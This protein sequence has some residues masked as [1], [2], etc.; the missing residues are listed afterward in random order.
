M[1]PL[2]EGLKAFN[3]YL[4]SYFLERKATIEKDLVFSSSGPSQ[5]D[6]IAYCRLIMSFSK[7]SIQFLKLIRESIHLRQFIETMV[8]FNTVSFFC[9]EG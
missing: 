9:L 5:T 4:K 3:E 2:R 8:N 1:K 6:S 7:Q